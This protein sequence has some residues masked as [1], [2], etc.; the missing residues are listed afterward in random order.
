MTL[1]IRQHSLLIAGLLLT[2]C[3]TPSSADTLIMPQE[4]VDVARASGCAQIDDF[5]HDPGMINP[6]Y[7]YGWVDG[8]VK[9]SA[10]FWCKNIEKG[11]KPYRL[12]FVIRDPRSLELKKADPK[13]L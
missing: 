5:Y 10:V 2:A 6:P 7:V 3:A 13:Q 1:W 12:M 11:N 4:L 9:D 8:E